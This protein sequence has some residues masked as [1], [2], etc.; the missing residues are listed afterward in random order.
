M[1]TSS[2]TP[3]SRMPSARTDSG[4]PLRP[5]ELPHFQRLSFEVAARDDLLPTAEG[6]PHLRDGSERSRVLQRRD[7]DERARAGG[8]VLRK[9]S[10]DPREDAATVRSTVEGEIVPRVRSGRKIGGIRQDPIESPQPG[11]EVG[12][13]RLDSE[14]L[15]ARPLP[16]RG[17]GPRI[18]VGRDDARAAAGGLE[19]DPTVSGPDFQQQR[20]SGDV[21][22]REEE[23]R[24]L[25]RGV[26]D[27]GRRVGRRAGRVKVAHGLVTLI[28]PTAL[29]GGTNGAL[30]FAASSL[31]YG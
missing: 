12:A 11:G 31:S 30:V 15:R 9:R 22:E 24:V 29:Y 18:E 14:P 16:Q 10:H 2:W 21:G 27:A 8:Q 20:P 1:G 13:D 5:G 3:C 4:R 17:E 19:S 7:H 26:H 25:A 23:L 6:F 28:S